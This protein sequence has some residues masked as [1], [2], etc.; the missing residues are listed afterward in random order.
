MQSRAS[1]AGGVVGLMQPQ[2][3]A[4]PRSAVRVDWA[5]DARRAESPGV[6]VDVGWN[7]LTLLRYEDNVRRTVSRVQ[8]GRLTGDKRTGPI[9]EIWIGSEERL[10]RLCGG[11]RYPHG[12][13]TWPPTNVVSNLRFKAFNLKLSPRL[14]LY[15]RPLKQWRLRE[16]NAAVVPER[17]KSCV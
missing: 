11:A 3:R 8:R 17:C 12:V 16:A 9:R 15:M 7:M 1:Q 6:A 5:R 13:W 4:Q 14:T 2:R 10:D